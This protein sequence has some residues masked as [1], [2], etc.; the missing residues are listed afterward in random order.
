MRGRW[1]TWAGALVVAVGIAGCAGSSTAPDWSDPTKIT[2]Y[3]G[4]HVDLSRMAKTASGVFYWDSIAGTGTY[5]A[6]V[7][8]QLTVHYTLWLPDGTL[9]DNHGGTAFSLT[10]DTTSVIRGWVD[11]LT[12]V[13]QGTARQ[14]VIPPSLAYGNAGNPGIPA[15][16]TLVFL[17]TA[18]QVTPATSGDLLSVQRLSDAPLASGAARGGARFR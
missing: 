11:G 3:S 8:D 14:L 2:Y 4:L 16:A 5:A 18:D 17:V 13:V 15:N 7:G 1:L 12:G 9:I 6:K 10:L